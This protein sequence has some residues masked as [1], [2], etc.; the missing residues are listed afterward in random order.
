MPYTTPETQ[1]LDEQ[2]LKDVKTGVSKTPFS[3]DLSRHTTDV[4]ANPGPIVG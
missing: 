4:E 1:N 3:H 2:P